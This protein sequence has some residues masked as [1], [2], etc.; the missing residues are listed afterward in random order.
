MFQIKLKKRNNNCTIQRGF[1]LIESLVAITILVTAILGP[2]TIAANG[3]ALATYAR[4]QATA[5]FLAQEGLEYIRNLRD[6][7][8]LS[9]VD[10]LVGIDAC[11]SNSCFVDSPDNT[12]SACSG[13]CPIVRYDSAT[14]VY[15][16][17]ASWSGTNFTRTIT[18][19]QVVPGE[20]VIVSSTVAWKR[21]ALA[22]RTLTLE[23]TL[24]N[25]HK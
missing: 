15:G 9:R 18:V 10:W 24:F 17:D 14:G 23:E 4:D 25:W 13:A 20:E 8:A 16:Y 6:S 19:T 3:I 5:F 11:L 12:I 7:N 2:M 21:G 1:T 22:A